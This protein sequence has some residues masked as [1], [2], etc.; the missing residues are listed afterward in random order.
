MQDL[1]LLDI[2]ILQAFTRIQN[3]RST[4]PREHNV[5]WFPT[6]LLIRRVPSV[7]ALPKPEERQTRETKET[8]SEGKEEERNAS[9]SQAR[10]DRMSTREMRCGPDLLRRRSSV[11]ST[12]VRHKLEGER[13]LITPSEKKNKCT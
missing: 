5:R 4:V 11:V 2:M 8:L 9:T 12:Y 3:G 6:S 13:S 1:H 10:G 7:G